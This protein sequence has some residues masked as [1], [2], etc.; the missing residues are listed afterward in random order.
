[1]DEFDHVIVNEDVAAAIE[2]LATV[3]AAA[4]GAAARM[5][6]VLL[7]VS[8]GIAAYKSVDVLRHP[9]APR[10]RRARR[11]DPRGPA[12]RGAGHVRRALGP[13]RGRRPV[14]RRGAARATTTWSSPGAPTCCWSR[15]RRPT[16]SPGWPPGLGDGLL[17]SV[18]LAFDGPVLIAPAMNTRMYLHPATVDNLALLV[19]RGV[20]VIP[21]GSG[22]LADG[23][24]GVGR[25]ADPVEIADAVEARLAG[26][27]SLAGRRVLVSA[28]GTRE[29]IDPVRY[30]GN[31]SSGR[32][33]WAVAEAARRRGA[34]GHRARLERRAAP[35][36]GHPVRRGPDRG[37]PAR[38]RP[39]RPSP[40]AT[41]W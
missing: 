41:S 34:R 13:P 1:M 2:E 8:G 5:A 37:R 21:P 12:L 7:G 24:T 27:G 40:P 26:A 22:L 25:L 19:A 10:P 15:R 20:Q 16:R 38:A 4:T 3:L 31:R 32:M 23:E 39:A 36:P 17:G 11:H 33:G 9:P 35:P 6:D 30:V 29:P 28:G 14:R 18:H